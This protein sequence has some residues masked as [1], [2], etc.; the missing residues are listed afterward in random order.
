MKKLEAQI[1]EAIR[2]DIAAGVRQAEVARKHSIS[3]ASVCR[4]VRGSRHAPPK[5]AANA[6]PAQG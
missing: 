6:A 2:T 5:E 4:I 3:P 1:V